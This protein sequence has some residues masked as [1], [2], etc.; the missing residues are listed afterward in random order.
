MKIILNQNWDDSPSEKNTS[1][2][3]LIDASLIDCLN[4][5]EELFI[6]LE[7]FQI[8]ELEMP[9]LTSTEIT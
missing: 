1:S 3:F 9:I 6:I 5:G 8:F 4:F 2:A 7:Q